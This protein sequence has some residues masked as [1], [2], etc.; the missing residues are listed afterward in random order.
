[1]EGNLNVNTRWLVIGDEFKILGGTLDAATE[2]MGKRRVELEQQ[3][4]SMGVSRINLDKLM[5]YLRGSNVE[6]VVPLGNATRASDF[7]RREAPPAPGRG[8]VSGLFQ[9]P[10]GQAAPK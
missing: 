8:R 5:G 2:V 6:D 3:A 4:K 7:K 10:D 9:T 1:M